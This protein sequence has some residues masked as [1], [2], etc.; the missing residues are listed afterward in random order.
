MAI[1]PT[2]LTDVEVI[3]SLSDMEE[4]IRYRLRMSEIFPLEM[5]QYRT[6]EFKALPITCLASI[7]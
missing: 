6:G 4:T 3:K 1:P 5:G 2:P 7:Y